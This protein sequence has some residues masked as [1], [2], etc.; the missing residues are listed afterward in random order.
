MLHDSMAAI[1]IAFFA[2]A[3]ESKEVKNDILKTLEEAKT[4]L[5]WPQ[6]RE[7]ILC[8]LAILQT[9]RTWRLKNLPEEKNAYISRDEEKFDART[10]STRSASEGGYG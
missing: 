2:G 6:W 5:E 3:K 1:T 9:L 7:A 8:K 10:F 4:S